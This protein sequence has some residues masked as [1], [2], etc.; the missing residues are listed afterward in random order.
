MCTDVLDDA[1]MDLP[2]R[3]RNPTRNDGN[4]LHTEK[5]ASRSKRHEWK[6][7]ETQMKG[8]ENGVMNSKTHS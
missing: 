7:N 2:D 3:N 1:V 8:F 4:G 6:E 5:T